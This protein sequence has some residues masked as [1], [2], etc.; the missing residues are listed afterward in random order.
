MRKSKPKRTDGQIRDAL[1]KEA[2]E[3]GMNPNEAYNRFFR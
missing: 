1:K 3:Q 2:R